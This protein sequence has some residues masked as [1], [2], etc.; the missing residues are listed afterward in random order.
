MLSIFRGIA[1]RIAPSASILSNSQFHTSAIL[2]AEP[3]KFLMYNDKVF[4]PQTE[5]EVPRKAFVCHSKYNIKYSPEKMWYIACMIRGMSIDEAIRQLRFV[6]KR[7]AVSILDTLLEAQ[8]LAIKEHNVEF[9]SNLWVAE[10]FTGKGYVI[11]GIRRHARMRVGRVEYKYC[12]YFVRLEEGKPPKDYYGN[13]VTPEQQLDKWM[14]EKRKRKI[15]N[16]L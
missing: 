3:R 8:E 14:D 9:K 12:H 1:S 5:D 16:S 10:S 7:G 4:E 15:Y 13:K 2:N 11:K 6:A